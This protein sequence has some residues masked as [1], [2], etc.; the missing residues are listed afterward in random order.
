[1]VE[2][3]VEEEVAEFAGVCVYVTVLVKVIVGV[4]VNVGDGVFV[5]D[6]VHEGV[7]VLVGAIAVF[8]EVGV[9]P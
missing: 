4:D 9:H 2:V 1:M 7:I 6:T 3:L 8:V 5:P